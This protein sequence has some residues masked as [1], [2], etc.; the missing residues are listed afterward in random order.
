MVTDAICISGSDALILG[1]SACRKKRVGGVTCSR[2]EQYRP[3]A[4][5]CTCTLLT[6]VRF[7]SMCRSLEAVTGVFTWSGSYCT[8]GVRST[9]MLAFLLICLYCC[10]VLCQRCFLFCSLPFSVHF[11]VLFRLF[12]FCLL[13]LLSLNCLITPFRPSYVRFH[14]PLFLSSLPTPSL[15]FP[16]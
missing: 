6:A 8:A 15:P 2:P 9:V 10:Y 14:F 11:N 16:S 4:G 1:C 12:S 13:F 7:C 5:N 3:T